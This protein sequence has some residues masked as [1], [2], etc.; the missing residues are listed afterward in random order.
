MQHR[1]TPKVSILVAARN[2][3]HC[4]ERCLSYL[5]RLNYPTDAL[6]IL[7][8]NDDSSDQTAE[9]IARFI[10]DK[11]HFQLIT[12]TQNIGLAKGKGNV[13]AQL[14]KHA[15]GEYFLFTDADIAVPPHWVQA[16][17][18]GFDTEKVGVINGLSTI[19]GTPLLARMQAIDWLANLLIIWF[20]SL[21]KIPITSMGNNMA[22][23]AKAYR[24]TGGYENLKFSLTE[25]YRLF[26]A[27]LEQGFEFRQL[28][29]PK[30][31]AVSLPITT[32][33]GWLVQRNRWITGACE[34]GWYYRL[35]VYGLV[36]L[37]L[38]IF[39]LFWYAPVPML[40]F[41]VTKYF[42]QNFVII[43]L[44]GHLRQKHLWR[45]VWF[46]EI[47]AFV[48]TGMLLVYHFGNRKGVEWKSRKY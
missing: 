47:Y 2:E 20:L 30:C 17:L 21:I 18:A 14:A 33:K 45:W 16:M 6:Q 19:S 43:G 9:I 8:G 23:T 42:I 40:L 26:K 12:I 27:I 25:D 31:V 35:I 36:A 11:P 29:S 44:L 13:L 39:T 28:M 41:W 24:A 46:Y 48:F 22:T 5:A 15:T 1:S 3:A 34:G 4:I 10:Q 37:Y 38:G 32:V 7:I